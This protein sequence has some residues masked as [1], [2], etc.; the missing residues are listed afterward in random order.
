[1]FNHC[2]GPFGYRKMT[3]LWHAYFSPIEGA[4]K[5]EVCGWWGAQVTIFFCRGC[6]RY[7]QPPRHW[8]KADLESRELLTFCVKRI[9]GLSKV[10]Q[11]RTLPQPSLDAAAAR[12]LRNFQPLWGCHVHDCLLTALLKLP[13]GGR[14]FTLR[15]SRSIS[16]ERTSQF[17]RVSS[18]FR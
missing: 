4:C 7:L 9:R 16:R 3:G 6:G 13:P 8:V 5:K 17:Q 10:Q 1:M 18:V 12:L 11:P 14:C 2:N 15:Y